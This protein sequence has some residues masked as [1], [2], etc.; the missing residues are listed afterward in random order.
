MLQ[1]VVTGFLGSGKTTLLNHLLQNKEGLK[2]A[3]FVNGEPVRP[4]QTPHLA[5]RQH[6]YIY[7]QNSHSVA[8]GFV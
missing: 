8:F 6:M 7:R 4:S 5:S 2:V 1:Q 3:V